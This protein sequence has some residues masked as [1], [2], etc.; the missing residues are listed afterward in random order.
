MVLV[1]FCL[2]GLICVWLR[3]LNLFI[4]IYHREFSLHHCICSLVRF[5][6]RWVEFLPPQGIHNDIRNYPWNVWIYN[7]PLLI[8]WGQAH[9]SSWQTQLQAGPLW[10]YQQPRLQWRTWGNSYFINSLSCLNLMKCLIKNDIK[11]F[12]LYIPGPKSDALWKWLKQ[13]FKISLHNWHHSWPCLKQIV[14][15][16]LA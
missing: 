16:A 8:M 6:H 11:T 1:E 10:W 4:Y 3:I 12:E 2:V 15:M 9:L 13:T 7:S 5:L 14:Y